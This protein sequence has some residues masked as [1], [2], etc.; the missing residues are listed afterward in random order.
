MKKYKDLPLFFFEDQQ[1]WLDWL[2]KNG[3]KEDA[4]WLAFAKKA[5]KIPSI[6]YEEAR[7]GAIMYGWIDGLKNAYDEQ[8]YVL[9]FTPRRTKSRW[10]KI[11]RAIAEDLIKHGKM[12]PSGQ[13][14]VDAAKEDGRWE[15]AY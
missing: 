1:S 5:A 14:A 15:A 7:E 11:N 9:R 4:V 6:T 10:S 8:F 13:E 12:M 2:E 3:S